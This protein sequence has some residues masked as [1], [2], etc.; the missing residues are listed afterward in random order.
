M[1]EGRS[2]VVSMAAELIPHAHTALVKP[3]ESQNPAVNHFAAAMS[4]NHR[5]LA[6]SVCSRGSAQ[7]QSLR[8][9]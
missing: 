4:E 9:E 7:K 1:F 2:Y 3:V 6:R 5:W 8:S